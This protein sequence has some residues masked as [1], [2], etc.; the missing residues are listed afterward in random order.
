VSA[1]S[2][3]N[4]LKYSIKGLTTTVKGSIMRV[5]S[6]GGDTFGWNGK[7]NRGGKRIDHSYRL[8]NNSHCSL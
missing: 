7:N 6:Q 1:F 8:S 2:F 5:T 3:E 4:N